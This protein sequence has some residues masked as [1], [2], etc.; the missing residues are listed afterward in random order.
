[1]LGD[2]NATH[3][4]GASLR[5]RST[6]SASAPSSPSSSAPR[7][8]SRSAP[9]QQHALLVRVRGRRARREELACRLDR[10]SGSSLPIPTSSGIVALCFM[11]LVL[12]VSTFVKPRYIPVDKALG[13]KLERGRHRVRP[14]A[15]EHVP[16]RDAV[17]ERGRVR[18]AAPLANAWFLL[19]Y[20]VAAGMIAGEGL[21]GTVNAVLQIGKAAVLAGTC[22]TMHHPRS[23]VV[24]E[25]DV[26]ERAV[27]PPSPIGLLS[28]L[29]LA[30]Y[31]LTG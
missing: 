8:M 25:A 1:M 19:G 15:D 22:V 17:R 3:L 28:L 16:R 23:W 13:P 29:R 4:L 2:L 10:V 31:A 6:R 9:V 24:D 5:V 26:G 11:A 30:K 14:R 21:G 7:C 18:V 20:A 12:P 27:R